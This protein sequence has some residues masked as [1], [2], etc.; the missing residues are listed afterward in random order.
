MLGVGAP[1]EAALATIVERPSCLLIT[2]LLSIVF[3]AASE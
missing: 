1:P 3:A 2:S